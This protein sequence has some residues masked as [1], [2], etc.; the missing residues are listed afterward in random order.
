MNQN[1]HYDNN[2]YGRDNNS[3]LS[4]IIRILVS[5]AVIV[6]ACVVIYIVVMRVMS[7]KVFEKI[8]LRPETHDSL[9]ITTDAN[10]GTSFFVNDDKGLKFR[11]EDKTFAREEWVEKNGELF[12]FDT[13]GYGLNGDL[14]NE[15]QVYTFE[16][17]KLKTIKRDTSYVSRAK[18]DLFSSIESAQYLVWLDDSEKNGNFYPIKFKMYSD[19]FEDYLGTEADKQYSSPNMMKIYMS[20]IYYLAA[21]KGTNFAGRLYRMRP[22]AIHKETVGIGVT[23]YIVLSDEIVYYC[24]GERVIK[25]KSWNGVNL[26]LPDN[27]ELTEDGEIVFK[28]STKSEA[29]PVVNDQGKKLTVDINELPKPDEE[30]KIVETSVDSVRVNVLPRPDETTSNTRETTMS[31]ETSNRANENGPKVEIGLSPGE[32]RVDSSQN[33]NVEIGVGPRVVEVEAPR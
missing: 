14:K 8:N 28:V 19:D 24:D 21:G 2:R 3:D 5:F 20:N 6:I 32:T 7:I 9:K 4:S 15:G 29:T 18:D 26:K 16:N 25:A 17:G 31:K 30:V 33:S 10:S 1:S 13:A 27:E 11:K 22:N 23:G 12:Y